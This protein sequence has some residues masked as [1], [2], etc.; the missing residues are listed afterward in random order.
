MSTTATKRDL[1]RAAAHD[2]TGKSAFDAIAEMVDALVAAKYS[3]DALQ[4]IYEDPLSVLVRDGWRNPGDP[5]DSPE[6]YEILLST[7]GPAT[8]IQGELSRGEPT[9]AHLEVQDWFTPW[10]EWRGEGWSEETLL[11]YARSFYFGE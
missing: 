1:D 2:E 10:Q 4:A 7:G 3:D 11:T 9:S 5:A 8:R 6:E